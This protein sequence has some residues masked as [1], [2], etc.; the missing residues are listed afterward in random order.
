MRVLSIFLL[1]I[2]IFLSACVGPTVIVMRNPATNEI[3]QCR[4]ANTGLSVTA[5]SMAARDC[6]AGY[7]AAGWIRMN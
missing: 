7:T 3:I 1:Q 5:E 4:G 2:A 6:A